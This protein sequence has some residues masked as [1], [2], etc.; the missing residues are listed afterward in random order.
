MSAWSSPAIPSW[1]PNGPASAKNLLAGTEAALGAIAEAYRRER[2]PL[3][4]TE[5]LALRVGKVLNKFKMQEHFMIEVGDDSFSFSPNEASLQE[6]A[7]LDGVYVLR[8][9]ITQDELDPAG[10]ISAHKELKAV[11]WDF[12]P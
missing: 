5:Q 8:T 1:P 6:E 3:R 2:R 4:G 10:V 9:T 7:A 11:E 12:R